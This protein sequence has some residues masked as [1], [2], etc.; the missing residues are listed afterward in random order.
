[1]LP[2]FVV[3]LALVGFVGCGSLGRRVDPPTCTPRFE[4][5]DGWLGGD[6]V[7]SVSLPD[8]TAGERHTLW[9]F[10]DTYVADPAKPA[11]SDRVGAAFI[12]NS[13]AVS[14]CRGDSFE[15]DYLWRHDFEER[16]RAFFESA[17]PDRSWYWPFDG[18]V[19]GGALFVGLVEV[20]AAAPDGPL[21]MPFALTGMS[22]ARIDDPGA[23]PASWRPRIMTLSRSQEA[24]PAS[25]MRIEGDHVLLFSFAAMRDGHQP[26]FLARL[27]LA[28]LDRDSDDLEPWLETW[29]QDGIWQA[30][31][32]PERAE[33]LMADNASEMSVESHGDGSADAGLLALYA[34]P[35]QTDGRGQSPAS[36]SNGVYARHAERATGPWSERSLV[37]TMPEASDPDSGTICYAAKEHPAFAR[38]G[39]LLFTYVCNLITMPD[40]DPWDAL[41]RLEQDMDLYVPRVIRIPVPESSGTGQGDRSAEPTH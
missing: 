38:P 19:H 28:A 25:A 33:I 11:R 9:L 26:R 1:M 3:A 18:F 22:L 36:R 30:G 16:P 12:H 15:I 8:R 10:G 34:S 4:P 31:L 37:Y 29:T 7:Y 5:V 27:P 14:S 2:V 40:Q 35:L 17:E 24:F 23:P 32:L 6:A 39:E 21:A 20:A 41:G 13:I